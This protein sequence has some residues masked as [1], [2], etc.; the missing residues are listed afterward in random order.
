VLD[1]QLSFLLWVFTLV[2][3]RGKCLKNGVPLFIGN[4]R[5]KRDSPK[6]IPLEEP[7]G[8]LSRPTDFES[9]PFDHSGI[10]PLQK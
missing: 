6:G 8:Q 4:L 7:P 10:S 2:T 5:R 1:D 3:A 9:A